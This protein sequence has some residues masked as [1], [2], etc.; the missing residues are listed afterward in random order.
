MAMSHLRNDANFH[1]ANA[2]K[3]LGLQC[4]SNFSENAPLYI[5]LGGLAESSG[6]G[7][8]PLLHVRTLR[9]TCR[10]TACWESKPKM[11]PPLAAA[12]GIYCHL[13]GAGRGHAGRAGAACVRAQHA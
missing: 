9:P 12:H 5:A 8:A 13:P 2:D 6:R 3:V 10:Y 7:S 11:S 1:K 4:H